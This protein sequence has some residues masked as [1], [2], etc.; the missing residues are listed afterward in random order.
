M[1]VDSRHPIA[2]QKH[3]STS[4]NTAKDTIEFRNACWV[5]GAFHG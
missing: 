2:T 3:Q 1:S 4:N 5:R